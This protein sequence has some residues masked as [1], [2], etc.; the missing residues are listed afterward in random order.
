MKES[1]KTYR[2]KHKN[3]AKKID[4]HQNLIKKSEKKLKRECNNIISQI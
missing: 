3:L 2:E 4:E 1:L